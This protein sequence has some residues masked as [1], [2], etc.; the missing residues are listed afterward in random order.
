[1]KKF[2]PKILRFFVCKF[3]V[4]KPFYLPSMVLVRLSRKLR[5]QYFNSNEEKS[6]VNNSMGNIKMEVDKNSYMGGSIYWS[7]YHHINEIL[8]LNKFLKNDMTFIDIGANQ[9]EF[10]LF[11]ASKLNNGKVISFEPVSKQYNYFIKNIELNNF[12][13]IEINQY[14]LSDQISKL[15]V[16]TSLNKKIHGGTHEGLSTLYKSEERSEFEE[17]IDLKIFDEEYKEKLSRLDFIKID[18]EG[19]ELFALK[20]M[21]NTIEKFKPDILIE[22]NNDTFK[23]AGYTINDILYFLEIFNYKP[24]KI[25]RGNLYEHKGDFSNW[26]NYIFKSISNQ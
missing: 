10:S 9:G 12:K 25:F 1:M 20:G 3:I 6:L 21:K 22:I 8:Y 23:S 5:Y 2:L 4:Y 15:P 14:G 26:G 24:F 18:I 19:A 13:N 17:N 11:A 7:G 16:Y